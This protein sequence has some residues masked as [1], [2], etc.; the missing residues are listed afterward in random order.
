M[1]W[2]ISHTQQLNLLLQ[3]RRDNAI[4]TLLARFQSV[5]QASSPAFYHVNLSIGSGPK[6]PLRLKT[7]Q[8]D[9]KILQKHCIEHLLHH[10][11]VHHKHES[12]A[13]KVPQLHFS[14]HGLG[15]GHCRLVD[16][17]RPL[18]KEVASGQ[19]S[20]SLT[21]D[22]HLDFATLDCKEGSTNLALKRDGV[23]ISIHSIL[24][25]LND[26]ILL[27]RRQEPEQVNLPQNPQFCQVRR[28][29]TA[30]ELWSIPSR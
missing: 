20:D 11:P 29:L 16:E 7:I 13:I 3:L 4:T 14:I 28:V 6:W 21:V 25:R 22:E 12:L 10:L 19:R 17:Q 15:C 8:C 9:A 27:R 23:A 1:E 2:M 18:T 26:V 30:G 5:L 24:R